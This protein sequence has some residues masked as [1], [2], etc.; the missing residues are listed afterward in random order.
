[1]VECW[2]QLRVHSAGGVARES[3]WNAC[4]CLCL[5]GTDWKGL[6]GNT[7]QHYYIS[8]L[9]CSNVNGLLDLGIDDSLRRFLHGHTRDHRR[10][11]NRAFVDGIDSPRRRSHKVLGLE[12]DS[13]GSPFPERG[14]I[15]AIQ[16]V[17]P[18]VEETTDGIEWNVVQAVMNVEGDRSRSLVQGHG[19]GLN[20]G[21]LV[22]NDLFLVLKS[23]GE[24]VDGF[25]EVLDGELELVVG[26]R[27]RLRKNDSIDV[28]AGLLHA[29][30]LRGSSGTFVLVDSSE[31]GE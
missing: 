9:L 7:I 27:G 8:R 29:V 22:L 11:K 16:P 17:G 6:K 30:V 18:L 15:I 1:M 20:E 28:E 23:L 13:S 14:I 12:Q 5:V 26:T 4:A 31:D 10:E 3:D 2:L 21:V 24:R 25:L 19:R